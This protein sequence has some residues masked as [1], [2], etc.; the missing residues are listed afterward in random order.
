MQESIGAA[1]MSRL[2]VKQQDTAAADEEGDWAPDS[3]LAQD[4]EKVI[5]LADSIVDRDDDGGDDDDGDD[6]ESVFSMS[7]VQVELPDRLQR[8]VLA[9]KPVPFRRGVYECSARGH[10]PGTRVSLKVPCGCTYNATVPTVARGTGVIMVIEAQ[11]K[12]TACPG[13]SDQLSR[14]RRLVFGHKPPLQSSQQYTPAILPGTTGG[15]VAML[16]Q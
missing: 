7:G 10:E 6:D 9:A 3:I 2:L 14:W 8:V 12:C 11:G 5:A 16:Q 13:P 15:Q 1:V 4:K